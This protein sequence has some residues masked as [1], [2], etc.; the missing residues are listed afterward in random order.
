MSQE[1]SK[2]DFIINH[3]Q[4]L[5]S[6]YSYGKTT[7]DDIANAC[8]MGKASL[9]HYFKNKE[10]IFEKVIIRERNFLNYEIEKSLK[11]LENLKEKI[12][13]FI[14]TR[15]F[16][17]PKLQNL[18]AILRD[19]SFDYIYFVKKEREK[20]FNDGVIIIKEIL[21]EGEN[22]NILTVKNINDTAI[23]LVTALRGFNIRLFENYDFE[24][25]ISV[26]LDVFFDGLLRKRTD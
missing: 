25:S 26:L 17:L 1:E 16:L 6:R 20:D 4:V 11:K 24:K 15:A 18:D 23:A 3:A 14:L 12:K 22:K 5:F 2:E 13:A 19:K 7:I 8:R 21:I 10:D 9:Y